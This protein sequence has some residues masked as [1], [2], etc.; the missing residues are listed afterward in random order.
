L[1]IDD[2]QLFKKIDQLKKL[3]TTAAPSPNAFAKTYQRAFDEGASSVVCICVSSVISATYSAAVT[4][5]DMFPGKDIAVIDSQLISMGQGFMVLAAAEAAQSGASKASVIAAAE[6][7]GKRVHLFALLSTL[8]YLA[9]S[10]RVG[11]LAA[12]MADT[13]NIKPI[14][15]VRNGKLDLLERIRTHKK[16]QERLLELTSQALDGKSIER[17]AIIH[18]NN[19]EGARELKEQLCARMPCPEGILTAE[20]TPGLSVHAGSGVVGVALVAS[21]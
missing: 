9:M 20:F 10:G 16:A 14:L 5:C 17:A 4:A 6:D 18:V 15:T 11:K 12:G 8:K 3:P 1:D 2:A 21:R 7:T 19:P 13:L